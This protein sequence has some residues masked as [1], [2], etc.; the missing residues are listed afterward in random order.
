MNGEMQKVTDPQKGNF[1]RI[2]W[3]Y[4]YITIYQTVPYLS[5]VSI[6]KLPSRKR[7]FI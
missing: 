4:L 3:G 1:I 6:K 7:K 5:M 2:F